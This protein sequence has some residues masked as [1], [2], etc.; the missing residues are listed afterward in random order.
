MENL[1]LDLKQLTL[2][3]TSVNGMSL[4]MGE[5]IIMILN[6]YLVQFSDFFLLLLFFVLFLFV[7][8]SMFL[9]VDF[10]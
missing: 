10:C 5:G 7:W 2:P 8:P 1:F 6:F 4:E 9:L 3:S